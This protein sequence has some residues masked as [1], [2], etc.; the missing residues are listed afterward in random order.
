M[1]CIV[2]VCNWSGTCQYF[3]LYVHISINVSQLI[4]SIAPSVLLRL[5]EAEEARTLCIAIEGVEM[6]GELVKALTTH[7]DAMTGLYREL[8]QLIT[9]ECD[10]QAK[11]D[12]I[13]QQATICQN[14]FK[15]RK[16]VANTMKAAASKSAWN[17]K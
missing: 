11:Y 10:D 3:K 8:N 5:K 13:F 7:S 6:S 17:A 9:Q 14:W 16:R 12:P 2:D 1:V 15:S 4:V